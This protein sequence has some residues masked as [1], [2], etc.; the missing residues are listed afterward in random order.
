MD[1]ATGAASWATSQGPPNWVFVV[2][3]LTA[4]H[5]WTDIIVSRVRQRF[6]G[7]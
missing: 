7:E 2:A 5:K 3:L 4:P 1:W 6:G